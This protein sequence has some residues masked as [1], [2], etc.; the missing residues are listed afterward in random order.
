MTTKLRFFEV[1][2]N[3]NYLN[4]A[5]ILQAETPEKALQLAINEAKLNKNS[6]VDLFEV[7]D[8]GNLLDYTSGLIII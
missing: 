4:S 7:D 5:Y 8:N 1:N 6:S 2:L 3:Q